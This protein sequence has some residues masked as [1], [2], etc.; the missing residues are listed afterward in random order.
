[1]N[2]LFANTWLLCGVLD[3][4][5]ATVLAAVSGG[6]GADVWLFVASGPFGDAAKSW[7]LAGVVAG[8]ATHFVIMAALVAGGFLLAYRS[9]IGMLVPWKAGTLYG[10]IIYGIMYGVVLQAR[11]GIPFPNPDK[12]KVALGLFPHIALVGIPI[13]VLAQRAMNTS[14][15]R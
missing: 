1:M 3:A 15:P 10:L 2:R 11:F 6:S 12:L 9:Q 7:G 4:I 13:F 5:Y 14:A 8:L